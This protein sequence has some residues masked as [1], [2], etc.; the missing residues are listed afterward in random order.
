V[1]TLHRKLSLSVLLLA[2]SGLAVAALSLVV[3]RTVIRSK[4][5]VIYGHAQDAI[6]LEHLY[7]LL[8]RKV[9]TSR[10]FLLSGNEEHW[11][12]ALR[13]R[14]D[15]RARIDVLRRRSPPREPDLLDRVARAEERH[16]AALEKVA[17]SRREGRDV[18]ASWEA[19]VRPL[20]EELDETIREAIRHEQTLLEDARRRSADAGSLATK[21]ILALA[22]ILIPVV[23]GICALAFRLL[24]RQVRAEQELAARVREQAVAVEFG[25]HA[26]GEGEPA[27]LAR[28]AA[29]LL[30]QA[31]GASLAGYFE[32]D[33]EEAAFRLAG[34]TGWRSAPS[35]RERIEAPGS[36]LQEA[37]ASLRARILDEGGAALLRRIPLF[38]AEGVRAGMLAAVVSRGRALGVLGVFDRRARVFGE[39]DLH[40][41]HTLA[42]VLAGAVERRRAQEK[43]R[44]AVEA[45]S[46]AILMLDRQGRVILAN[47]Q[48][49][50][51]FGYPRAELLGRPVASLVPERDREAFAL[52]GAAARGGNGERHVRRM[53]GVLVP[54]E[55]GLSPLRTE[56]GEFVLA[57]V[58]DLTRRHRAEEASRHLAAI[59]ESSDDAII[60]ADRGGIIRT[61]NAAAERLFGA[62]AAEV[63]GTSILRLTPA[64]PG[65]LA[66]AE[67]ELRRVLAGEAVRSEETIRQDERGRRIP[68]ALTLS[69][70]HGEHDEIVGISMIARDVAREREAR[71]E[72]RRS[73]EHFRLL[74]EAAVDYG[75]ILLDPDGRVASWNAGA[76]RMLGYRGPEVIGGS[77]ARFF[78][79]E[80][81]VGGLP[82]RELAT[83][84]RTG[85]ASDE[86]WLQRKDGSRFWASGTTYALRHG[87]GTLRGFLKMFRDLTERKRL[88]EEIRRLNSALE[89]RVAERTMQLEAFTYSV[90]HDLRAPLRAMNGFSDALLHDYGHCLDDLG[91]EYARRITAACARM[92][93]LIQD[94]LAYSRLSGEDFA[95]SPVDVD[96]LVA[97]ILQE[98]EP[99]IAEARGQF[100]VERPLGTV[101]GHKVTLK[102]VLYN[103]L[104][105]A[106]KFVAEGTA[107]QGRIRSERVGD[108]VRLWVEDNGIGIDPAHQERIFGV[109]ERLHPEAYSGTGI[110]LAIVKKGIERM[111]GRVGVESAPGRGSRFFVELPA[112]G[113]AE[114]AA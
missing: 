67:G 43:V 110:G 44:A 80:D 46:H 40:L 20:R 61:W 6:E 50:R 21:I 22:G 19:E 53:D 9:A 88:E 91:R 55:I 89:A 71:D 79:P 95:P 23:G 8:E 113:A 94:L 25:R 14:D 52:A 42:N 41:L 36:A 5:L 56:E 58:V 62:S 47:A 63:V 107:P 69:P 66:A 86:N 18:A 108:R 30:T 39:D 70:I 10:G 114:A 76:E 29:T 12:R 101:R 105:N 65:A 37:A 7:A 33:P 31:T 54:V 78:T 98:M 112:A 4:D 17:A 16:Q 99:Q 73:E 111:G 68:V 109:F 77:F 26:L 102:Q 15:L 106:L 60:S 35:E 38:E 64:E 13:A 1:A 90:S 92:D 74:V 104:L 34:G 57:S 87:D 75:I 81:V 72:L 11:A 59:V 24:A 32:A 84:T 45:V 93:A 82:G 27:A 2:A 96:A 83:A 100:R 48:A 3:L 51:L 28:E 97:E 103:L 85:K 49:E